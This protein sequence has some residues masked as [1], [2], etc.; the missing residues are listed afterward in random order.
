MSCSRTQHSDAGEAQTR[1]PSVLIHVF[2][3]LK[4]VFVLAN[5]ADPD[6]MKFLLILFSK[7]PVYQITVRMKWDN[8][9]SIFYT[10]KDKH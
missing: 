9:N 10:H 5:S 8:D 3:F 4:I 7:V 6:L 2:L 1:C